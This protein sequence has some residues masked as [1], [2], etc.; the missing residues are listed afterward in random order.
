M[1]P[2]AGTSGS[3]TDL[4]ISK[5]RSTWDLTIWS[6]VGKL[7][8]QKRKP[9]RQLIQP[10]KLH[11]PCLALL[12]IL[13]EE[14][15]SYIFVKEVA[16]WGCCHSCEG[17]CACWEHGLGPDHPV[18]FHSCCSCSC[19]DLPHKQVDYLFWV[20]FLLACFQVLISFNITG[21]I[22]D[23]FEICIFSS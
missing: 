13:W 23:T 3:A 2:W 19:L 8:K 21:R 18:P 1:C 6:K 20:F 22:S 12:I 14:C 16:G 7:G 4:E 11:T 15:W 9:T 10:Q 17:G 5:C